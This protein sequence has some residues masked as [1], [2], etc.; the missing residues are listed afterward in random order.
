MATKVG[1]EY[2]KNTKNIRKSG[3]TVGY[4]SILFGNSSNEYEELIISAGTYADTLVLQE[5]RLR[6]TDYIVDRKSTGEY[7]E[8]VGLISGVYGPIFKTITPYEHQPLTI[9][10]ADSSSENLFVTDNYG[11]TI[12]VFLMPAP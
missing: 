6:Q 1:I 8:E 12:P 3:D 11:L 5:E 9:T 10:K 4:N 2:G 7:E